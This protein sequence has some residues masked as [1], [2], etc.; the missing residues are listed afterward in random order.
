MQAIYEA[1]KSLSGGALSPRNSLGVLQRGEARQG[2][3]NVDSS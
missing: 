1:M 3:A 2:N